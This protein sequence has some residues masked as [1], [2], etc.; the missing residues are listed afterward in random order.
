MKR[1]QKTAVALYI[2]IGLIAVLS[3]LFLLRPQGAVGAVATITVDG[4]VIR[5]IQLDTAEDEIF[6]IAQAG[7]VNITF[8]VKAHAIHFYSSDCPDKICVKS[9]FLSR[10]M[11]IASCLPNK[12]VLSVTTVE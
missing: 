7:G 10:D 11:D 1:E 6:S 2:V 3:V 5:T 12:T 9:G 4:K 8:E